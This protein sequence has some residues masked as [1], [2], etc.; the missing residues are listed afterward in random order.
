[1]SILLKLRPFI[2]TLASHVT[3][4]EYKILHILSIRVPTHHVHLLCSLCLA[5]VSSY[6]KP[7]Q[8]AKAL[9]IIQRFAHVKA[10]C[11]Q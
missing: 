7:M 11:F 8:L 4:L 2:A 10:T 3:S 9:I 1:M 5:Y 6:L